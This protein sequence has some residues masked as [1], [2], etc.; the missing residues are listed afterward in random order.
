MALTWKCPDNVMELL[1]SVKNKN[2]PHLEQA[3][4]VVAFNDAKPFVKNRLNWGNISRFS[5]FNKIWQSEK[6]DFCVV[7]CSDLWHS[8]LDNSQREPLLDLHLCRCN[9]EYIPETVIEGKKKQVVK[10][11]WGRVK[12]TDEIKLDANGNPKWQVSPID[13][14]VLCKNVYR[15]G[16]WCSELGAVKDVITSAVL[17]D[18]T[19]EQ[20]E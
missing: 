18:S 7:I 8:I 9:V 2:H 17:V 13:F 15:Y 12:Y 10:D 6:Y 16:L 11:E 19:N 4:F 5:E 1:D 20:T 3:N 14:A